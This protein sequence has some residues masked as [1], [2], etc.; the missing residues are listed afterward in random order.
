MSAP[1]VPAT[2]VRAFAAIAFPHLEALL[3]RNL[4]VMERV[5]ARLVEDIPAGKSLL[6]FGSGHS[7][8]FP[9]ELYHRAGGASF[10]IPVVA[11]FLLPT[12]GP[13]VVRVLERTPR[14]E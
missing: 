4:E 7:G 8:I 3:E 9:L 5:T 14:S 2:D 1:T 12:A 10:V 6:V 11:D 13:P